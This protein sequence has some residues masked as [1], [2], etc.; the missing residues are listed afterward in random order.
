MQLH[1]PL[2]DP[3]THN[4]DGYTLGYSSSAP[5]QHECAYLT[6]RE[7]T[8]HL[9]ISTSTLYRWRKLG[10][11]AYRPFLGGRIKYKIEDLDRYMQGYLQGETQQGA[12]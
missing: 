5:V 4:E 12:A 8:A 6:S 7:A 3:A 9:R 10:L 2:H 11:K 1:Q